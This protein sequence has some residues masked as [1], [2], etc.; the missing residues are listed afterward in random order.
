MENKNC[1][2]GICE[3]LENTDAIIENIIERLDFLKNSYF[4]ALYLH[5][6]MSR[7][8][9]EKIKNIVSGKRRKLKGKRSNDIELIGVKLPARSSRYEYFHIIYI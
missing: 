3:I 8:Y 1:S 2:T 9:A 5:P 6:Y 7:E 4:E